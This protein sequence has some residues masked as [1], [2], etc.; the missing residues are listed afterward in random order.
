[1]EIKSYYCQCGNL[2]HQVIISFDNSTTWNDLVFINVHLSRIGFLHRLKYA[3]KYLF[4]IS[5]TDSGAYD[6]ILFN[7]KELDQLISHLKIIHS[8]M[9][10][11]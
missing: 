9:E 1:M 2:E 11:N 10:E 8:E 4:G 5:R 3:L 7:K 6:E